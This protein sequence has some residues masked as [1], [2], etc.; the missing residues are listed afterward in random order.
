MIATTRRVAALRNIVTSSSA[1]V[2]CGASK[3][4]VNGSTVRTVTIPV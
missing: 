1:V 3:N 4:T 2:S